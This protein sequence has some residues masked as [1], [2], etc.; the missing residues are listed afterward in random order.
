[1]TPGLLGGNRLTL[2]R[3]GAEYFPALKAAIDGAQREIFLETYLFEDDVA[4]RSIAAA[5]RD[6]A[7]RG[8]AAHLLLDGFG[9]KDMS[10]AMLRQLRD[11]GVRVLIFR[12]K[13]SPLT[14]RRNRL[15]RMH[16]K[17][18]VVDGHT[19][20]VGGI[21]IIDDMHTPGHI[22]PRYDYAVQ[23]EGPLVRDMREA[24]ARLS[25][26]IAWA[27]LHESWPARRG[28]SVDDS[29]RGNQRAALVMRDNVRHRS[30]IEDAYLAAIASARDEIII[31]NAYFFPGIRFRRALTDAAQRG[32]RI[33]LQQLGLVEYMLLNYASRALYGTLL[34]AGV[35][36]Y[37]YHKS[38]LHAKVAVIDGHWATVGSSN[39][40][41]FSL[42]LSR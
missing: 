26:W 1:M 42:M 20:F 17:L 39:I 33:S 34:Q 4:G 16:R 40:D 10:P 23:V 2:L 8:A 35:N 7:A 19:G 29:P 37:E 13:I 38:F 30:D 5:L 18:V 24:A 22:P 21:N 25:R 11:G 12:R 41:T 27:T 32:L 14:L 28:V 36:I 9:C 3:S 31:A 15:R 6:A